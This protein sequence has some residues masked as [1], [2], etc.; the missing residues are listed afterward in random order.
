MSSSRAK[1]K[2]KDDTESIVDEIIDEES[3]IHS[4]K[5]DTIIEEDMNIG[6]ARSSISKRKDDSIKEDSILDNEYSNDNFESYNASMSLAARN[7]LRFG[8]SKP[9]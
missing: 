8:I 4:S 6:T 9:D 3:N 1:G 5:D 2:S 7:R